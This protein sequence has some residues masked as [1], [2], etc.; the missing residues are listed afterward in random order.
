MKKIKFYQ[1]IAS[2]A[3]LISSINIQTMDE[4]NSID[5]LIEGTR[6]V[7]GAAFLGAKRMYY[8]HA[9]LLEQE[10]DNPQ[11]PI[12][13]W[14]A[15]STSN[16]VNRAL[17]ELEHNPARAT[18]LLIK[19]NNYNSEHP[20]KPYNVSDVAMQFVRS[21]IEQHYAAQESKALAETKTHMSDLKAQWRVDLL[22][23]I[24]QSQGKQ[25]E[26]SDIAAVI[27][28]V[29]GRQPDFKALSKNFENIHTL[30]ENLHLL[31]S[32]PEED[33]TMVD[34]N[35]LSNASSTTTIAS[36][37]SASSSTLT[38]KSLASV[39]NDAAGSSSAASTTTTT[40][41]ATA[42]S[43]TPTAPLAALVPTQAATDNRDQN[44][45]DTDDD[46]DNESTQSASLNEKQNSSDTQAQTSDSATKKK[47]KHKKK[48]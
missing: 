18:N 27:K 28:L 30:P 34:P 10:L 44:D 46:S 16:K 23:L 41:T 5:K 26:L 1:I 35:V 45:H 43:S 39:S 25:K 31:L 40:T 14:D 17:Q 24:A 36:S 9:T 7:V 13:P 11:T 22:A 20:N 42:T 3:Y 15:V 21:G 6:T 12:S 2:V 37:S 48:K 4:K 38:T 19:I 29:K 33:F 8:G 32:A 47:K